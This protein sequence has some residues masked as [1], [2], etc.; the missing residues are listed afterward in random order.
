MGYCSCFCP[1]LT[2]L[3][4]YSYLVLPCSCL[5]PAL[6]LPHFCCAPGLTLACSRICSCPTDPTWLQLLPC[7]SSEPALLL[8]LPFSYLLLP[9]SCLGPAA[10]PTLLLLLPRTCPCPPRSWS[11]PP[12]VLLCFA[13]PPA[14]L[15]PSSC[16][17]PA[18]YSCSAPAYLPTYSYPAPALFLL[19]PTLVWQPSSLSAPYNFFRHGEIRLLWYCTVLRYRLC[20]SFRGHQLD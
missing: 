15:L 6:L 16:P 3:L 13:H 10:A 17:D 11:A 5:H 20:I 1:A 7:S 8:L 19:L 14:L 2:Q 4:P 18:P 9:R 12:P